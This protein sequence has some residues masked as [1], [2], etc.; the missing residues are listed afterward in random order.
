MKID[1]NIYNQDKILLPKIIKDIKKL[2]QNNK[3]ILGDGCKI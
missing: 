1:F 3:F 2:I